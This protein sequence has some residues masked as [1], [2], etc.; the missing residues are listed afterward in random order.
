M[1]IKQ[2][3]SNNALESVR[4]LIDEIVNRIQVCTNR[5]RGQAHN[6]LSLLYISIYT[7]SKSA[8]KSAGISRAL[9]NI[10]RSNVASNVICIVRV[11][12]PPIF[13]NGMKN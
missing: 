8:I 5:S 3:S 13:H 1:L 7:M 12:A 4:Q 10:M 11:P 2:Q 9:Q 6:F